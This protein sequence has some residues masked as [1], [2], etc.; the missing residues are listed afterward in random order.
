MMFVRTDSGFKPDDFSHEQSLVLETDMGL[1][2]FNSC[3]HGGAVNIIN[4]IKSTFPGKHIYGL[5]GGFH[6]FN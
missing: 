4:E 1:I 2:I 6:L 3:S 5:I